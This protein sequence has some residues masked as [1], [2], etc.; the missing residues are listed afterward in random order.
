[1]NLT[2]M[3]AAVTFSATMCSAERMARNTSLNVLQSSSP[4]CSTKCGK[5]QAAEP[6][7]PVPVTA[8]PRDKFSGEKICPKVSTPTTT[9]TNASKGSS[10]HLHYSLCNSP[11]MT[12][13]MVQAW[14]DPLCNTSKMYVRQVRLT[15]HE[16]ET[17]QRSTNHLL[18]NTIT[19][20]VK[21][22]A[23]LAACI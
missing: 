21:P 7:P 22:L 12:K 11:V 1:M 9:R 17:T 5:Q 20:V 6:L 13:G 15:C 18:T 3:L 10:S 16:S 14:V 4:Q 2:L 8:D 19:M 23:P